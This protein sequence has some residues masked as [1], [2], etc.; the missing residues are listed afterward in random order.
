MQRNED[1]PALNPA[2]NFGLIRFAVGQTP[3][4]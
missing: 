4:Q 3:N 2:L 1:N